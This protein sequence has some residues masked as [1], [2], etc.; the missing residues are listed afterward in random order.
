[1]SLSQAIEV[2]EDHATVPKDEG[3]RAELFAAFD[4]L[5]TL[6]LGG[7]DVPAN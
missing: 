3:Q 6:A 7:I 4:L 5:H 1:M 2:L